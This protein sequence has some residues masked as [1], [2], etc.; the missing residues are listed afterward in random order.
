M[1]MSFYAVCHTCQE[2]IADT[3]L[4]ASLFVE[5]LALEWQK[6]HVD[7]QV[8]IISDVLMLDEDNVHFDKC[9]E[10]KEVPQP[11]IKGDV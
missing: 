2:R 3:E 6:E 8:D 7:H 10:Y 5:A 9:M 1:G 4:C 11:K